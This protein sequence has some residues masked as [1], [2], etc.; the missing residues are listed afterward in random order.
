MDTSKTIWVKDPHTNAKHEILRRY[1]QAWFPILASTSGRIIYLD[2]FAGPGVY[3]DGEE[4]SPIIAIRCLLEHIL[5]D[6][7]KRREF[8][9]IFIEKD[10]RRVEILKETIKNRFPNLPRNVKLLVI[11]AEFA[12]TMKKILDNL[13]GEGAKLAPTFAFLDPFGFSGLPMELVSRM[14][15]Y[16]KCEVLISFMSGFVNRFVN[17]PDEREEVFDELFGSSE[18]KKVREIAGSEERRYFIIELYKKQLRDIAEAKYVRSF[19]MIGEHNQV[20]YDLV[21]ATKHLLGLSCMKEAMWK[22]DPR[23][24]YRFSDTTDVKQ[25]YLLDYTDENHWIPEAASKVYNFFKGKMVTIE[26][27]KKYVIEETLYIFRRSILK[28]LE[29]QGKIINVVGEGKKVY[30]S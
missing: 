22:V 18:W 15:R 16:K 26:E 12:P 10:E 23:G 14:M 3:E 6:R 24:T 1:L 7:F 25:K 9:F 27:I 11:N 5:R 4:G 28:E 13:E 21:F 19:E 20:I 30:L 29:I 8:V 2:G 17:V